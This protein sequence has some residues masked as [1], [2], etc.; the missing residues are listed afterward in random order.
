MPWAG[1]NAKISSEEIVWDSTYHNQ[2]VRKGLFTPYVY[3]WLVHLVWQIN[4]EW[5]I[6]HVH[7]H[8]YRVLRLEFPSY[9]TFLS[10]HSLEKGLSEIKRNF[11]IWKQGSVNESKGKAQRLPWL[12]A[13]CQNL[14]SP[15]DLNMNISKSTLVNVYV[16]LLVYTRIAGTS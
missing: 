2:S 15:K 5:L 12:S 11:K 10:L 16:D 14:M 1:P 13:F 6:V 7:V 4:M 8:V 3:N 9:E